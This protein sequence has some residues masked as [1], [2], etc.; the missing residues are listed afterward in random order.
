MEVIEIVE[1]LSIIFILVGILSVVCNRA[2]IPTIFAYILAG[3]FLGKSFLNVIDVNEVLLAFSE[4]GI[5]LIMLYVGLEFN[6]KKLKRMNIET[7]YLAIL[8]IILVFL[9]TA[10]LTKFL[11]FDYLTSTIL[12]AIF[13]I[14]S[15]AIIVKILEELKKIPEKAILQII[16]ILI[17]E[18][19]AAILFLTTLNSIYI[20]KQNILEKILIMISKF[21]VITFSLIFFGKKFLPRFI[22]WINEN[23]TREI[24]ILTILGISF[25]MAYLMHLVKFSVAIG[26]FIIGAI[27]GYSKYRSEIKQMIIP[28]KDIFSAIFFIYVGLITNILAIRDIFHIAILVGLI[29]VI[30]K[31]LILSIGSFLLGYSTYSS[32]IIGTTM[33][34]RGEF[35]FIM[36]EMG[37]RNYLIDE[38]LYSIIVVSTIIT[39]ISSIILTKEAEKIIKIFGNIIPINLKEYLRFLSI[40][41][42]TLSKRN[43]AIRKIKTSLTLITIYIFIIRIIFILVKNYLKKYLI[44]DILSI[45]VILLSISILLSLPFFYGIFKE[46]KNIFKVIFQ[47]TYISLP[48]IKSRDISNTTKLLVYFLITGFITIYLTFVSGYIFNIESILYISILPLIS[49]ISYYYVS[50]MQR[51][52]KHLRNAIKSY[53]SSSEGIEVETDRIRILPNSIISRRKIRVKDF[54]RITNVKIVSIERKHEMIKNPE[55]DEII[56]VGDVLIVKGKFKDIERAYL[57]LYGLLEEEFY[58]KK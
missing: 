1:Q 23:T 20:I 31:S 24:T 32:L 3:M 56:R 6:L 7:I 46:I 19:L 30:S 12:G 49:F 21:L 14:S 5:I 44:S 9:I 50:I 37:L 25:L 4:I 39:I 26:S 45:N 51:F 38:I 34:S 58:Y 36:A 33:I 15:T 28:I 8:E 16:G 52:H 22:D 10:Y 2:G 41:T 55:Q 13:S 47:Y 29:A 43:P 11:G 42:V 18:D 35:S 40:Q 57:Y 48:I 53:L 54:E 17:I 27:L